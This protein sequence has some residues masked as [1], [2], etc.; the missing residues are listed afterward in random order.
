LGIGQTHRAVENIDRTQPTR[1]VPSVLTSWQGMEVE[2]DPKAVLASPLYRFQE[3][4][5]GAMSVLPARIDI[6]IYATYVHEVSARKGSP[7]RV[8]IAQ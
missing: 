8:S 5:A 2:V 3:V 6:Y 1:V 7:D 4:T